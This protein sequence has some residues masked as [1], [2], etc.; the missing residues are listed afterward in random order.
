V[1]RTQSCVDSK[2][3][4]TGGA[5]PDAAQYLPRADAVTDCASAF[6]LFDSLFSEAQSDYDQLIAQL[7]NAAAQSSDGFQLTAATPAADESVAYELKPQDGNAGISV[8]GRIAGGGTDTNL[9]LKQSLTMTTDPSAMGGVDLGS[10]K[11]ALDNAIALD[12]TARKVVSTVNV[13]ASETQG[14]QTQTQTV[15]GTIEVADGADKYVHQALTVALGTDPNQA[16]ATDLTARLVDANTLTITGS[17]NGAGMPGAVSY[18][19]TKS[20]AGVC[21]VGK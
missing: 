12:L 21:T 5:G 8:T 7:K 16:F 6:A 11:M 9:S 4:T 1:S 15:R 18:K 19:V 17:Y 14:G 10:T 20:P 2:T 3:T 13:V